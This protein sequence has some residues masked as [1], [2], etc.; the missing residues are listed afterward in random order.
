MSRMTHTAFSLVNT[1]IPQEWLDI[2]DLLSSVKIV[3]HEV[4]DT[5]SYYEALRSNS[6][7]RFSSKGIFTPSN[8]FLRFT[9]RYQRNA[10]AQLTLRGSFRSSQPNVIQTSRIN[11]KIADPEFLFLL[12]RAQRQA[13]S[14]R[15]A[16]ALC[17][18][19]L[20][21]KELKKRLWHHE[22][23]KIYIPYTADE[24][25][26]VRLMGSFCKGTAQIGSNTPLPNKVSNVVNQNSSESLFSRIA[27]K[28]SSR[29]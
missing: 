16:C 9:Y 23:C 27:R 25:N 24:E 10:V 22:L 26:Q 19:P 11:I 14:D 29:L 4:D 21:K 18:E 1:K 13:R 15:N 20:S 7:S 12:Y 5:T 17:G 2:F 3:A 6:L 8:G 28:F